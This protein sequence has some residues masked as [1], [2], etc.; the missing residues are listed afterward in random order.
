MTRRS[1]LFHRNSEMARIAK[2]LCVRRIIR[3]FVSMAPVSAGR[4][5]GTILGER[6]E[7]CIL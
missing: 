3:E 4:G 7:R 1:H 6:L 2:I 5:I